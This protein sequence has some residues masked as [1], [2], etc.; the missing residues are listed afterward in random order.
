MTAESHPKP[1]KPVILQ[2]IPE[3]GAGGAEQGC[4]D[5]AAGLVA[6]G[7]T[8]LVA[9]HNG[10]RLREL[11]RT[12][13]EHIPLPVHSKNPLTISSNAGKLAKI[14]QARGVGIIHA[15]SRAPA[16]SALKAAQKTGIPFV[17]TCHAPYNL[18]EPGIART[19]KKHYNSSITRA[20]R[21]IAISGYVAE[22]LKRE[23]G[24]GDDV[25]RVIQ[26]G[27]SLERFHPLS[28]S[29]E[30]IIKIHR[31]WRL[32]DGATVVLMPGRLTRWKGQMVMI[33]AM[34]Q[35]KDR[36]DLFCVMVGSDQG[37]SQ[38]RAELESRIRALG[39]ES[40]IRLMDH[41]DDM[42]AAYVVAAAVVSASIEPEGFGRIAI[43]GQAMGRPTIATDHGGSRETILPGNTG[44][45]VTPGD[46]GALARAI[47]EA[48]DL[49]MEDR[50]HLATRAMSHVA[51][52]FSKDQMV[53]KTL[54][55]YAELLA[56]KSQGR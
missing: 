50:M 38:Y 11:A 36:T 28:V 52:H 14:I 8:A 53:E 43:E 31:A 42:A 18:P 47:R 40:R 20:D 27:L 55:V 21:V 24:L 30:R 37:R 45:L 3:L 34:E 2:V 48:L 23:Y 22:Y 5:V 39:L 6:R 56:E 25:I 9:S 41:C 35:L 10:S 7:A 17:T 46:A 12:G 16:W 13:A 51:A 4:L 19:L 49:S 15:R 33:D 32:P 1:D 54:D 29:A 26:R 44:W